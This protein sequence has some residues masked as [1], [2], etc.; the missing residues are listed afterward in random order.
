ML[1]IQLFLSVSQLFLQAGD[2]DLIANLRC[3]LLS[4][5]L[6]LLLEELELVLEPPLLIPGRFQVRPGQFDTAFQLPDLMHQI[7]GFHSEPFDLLLEVLH[8]GEVRTFPEAIQHDGIRE[9]HRLPVPVESF[10]RVAIDAEAFL[11]EVSEINLGP[12]KG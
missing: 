6:E 11:V 12:G 2:F 7:L 3:L 9:A 1:P 10:L 5:L 4:M 8:L